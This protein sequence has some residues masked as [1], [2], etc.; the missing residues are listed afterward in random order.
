MTG[1]GGIPEDSTAPAAQGGG[2]RREEAI[3][4]LLK[5]HGDKRTSQSS[6]WKRSPGVTGGQPLDGVSFDN[7]ISGQGH[8]IIDR[9]ASDGRRTKMPCQLTCQA[10]VNELIASAIQENISEARAPDHDAYLIERVRACRAK[11]LAATRPPDDQARRSHRSAE[12]R[13]EAQRD[14]ERASSK[15]QGPCRGNMQQSRPLEGRADRPHRGRCLSC[16]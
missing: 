9:A 15:P 8:G 14:A 16:Q 4:G 12:G 11:R 13:R 3:R 5:R 2:C 6:T 7:R 10:Q 1:E